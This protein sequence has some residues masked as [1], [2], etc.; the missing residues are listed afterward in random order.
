SC[1]AESL[2]PIFPNRLEPAT[3]KDCGDF[4]GRAFIADL[5]LP[6]GELIF[7]VLIFRRDDAATHGAMEMFAALPRV[8]TPLGMTAGAPHRYSDRAQRDRGRRAPPCAK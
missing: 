6:G 8:T 4:G 3:A 1:A 2:I 7:A 5:K